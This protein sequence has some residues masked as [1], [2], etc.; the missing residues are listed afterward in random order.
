MTL[1]IW[2][3]KIRSRDKIIEDLSEQKTQNSEL[4]KRIENKDNEINE[5]KND[6]RKLQK[7]VSYLN[8]KGNSEVRDKI[9]SEKLIKIHEENK[10]LNE[11]VR[12]LEEILEESQNLLYVKTWGKQRVLQ[13]NQKN[14]Y[15]TFIFKVWVVICVVK[16]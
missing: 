12:L 10:E 2:T 14:I 1:E 15:G 4:N 9:N 6:K 11:T 7:K 8:L 5:L 3:K 13:W 16:W